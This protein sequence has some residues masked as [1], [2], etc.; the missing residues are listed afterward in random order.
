MSIQEK[1]VQQQSAPVNP[2]HA[3][4]KND[5]LAAADRPA[6]GTFSEIW[7]YLSHNKKWWLTPIILV[8]LMVG[9]LVI[10]AGTSAAPLIY[11]LF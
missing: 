5:F 8:L 2:S 9:V 1:T 7:S 4:E 6:S 3:S 11:T 10:L